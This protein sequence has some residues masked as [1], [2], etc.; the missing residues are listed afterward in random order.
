VTFGVDPTSTDPV[1]VA[2]SVRIAWTK[3]GSISTRIDNQV[4]M[5]PYTV[6]LGTDGSE[7]IVGVDS[8]QALGGSGGSATPP[9]IALL[10]HKRTARGGR[11]G[12]GRMFIPWATQIADVDER[13]TIASSTLGFTNTALAVFLAELTTQG[14]PMV[15]LHDDGRTPPG[16]PNVVTS[17]TADA[18]VGTQRRRLGR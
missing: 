2:A 8:T 11:R 18:I 10:V 9:N 7:A 3:V 6:R 14:C 12:R 4:T 5:G 15:V 13:G 17:L 16:A 1:A